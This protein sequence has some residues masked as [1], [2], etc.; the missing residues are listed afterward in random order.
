MG[1]VIYLTPAFVVSDGELERLTSAIVRV[2][3]S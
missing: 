1:K 3:V 2:V